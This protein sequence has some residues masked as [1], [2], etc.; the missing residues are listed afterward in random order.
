MAKKLSS[1]DEP[2]VCVCSF[3]NATEDG[4]AKTRLYEFIVAYASPK[5]L[6][7][8]A[9]AAFGPGS[10]TIQKEAKSNLSR[11]AF[12][13]LAREHGL[14]TALHLNLRIRFR[15]G[16]GYFED[17]PL[18]LSG[19]EGAIQNRANVKAYQE[20]FDQACRSA[21]QAGIGLAVKWSSDCPDELAR[22]ADALRLA[23]A[24]QE[25]HRI[26][27]AAAVPESAKK[28]RL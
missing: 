3:L 5:Q 27:Q 26:G 22:A 2:A 15:N 28:P 16:Y 20:K 7:E 17:V 13:W 9:E 21:E 11:R 10:A 4:K 8:I 25:R 1:C 14:A 19:P 6:L 23:F 24:L 18:H 12:E